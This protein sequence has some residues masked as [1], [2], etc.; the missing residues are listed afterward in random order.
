M[1]LHGTKL[2]SYCCVMPLIDRPGLDD[3]GQRM[4][5][6]M[7]EPEGGFRDIL[8]TLETPESIRKKDGTVVH[9]DPNQIAL[10]RKIV[11]PVEK[12]GRGA[13][14]SLRIQE[15]E[16]AAAATWPPAEQIQMGDWL[17]RATG[18]FTGRANS[19]LPLGKPPFGNPGKPLMDALTDVI[20]FYQE[21]DLTPLIHVSLPTYEE[22]D[23]ELTQWGWEKRIF[24]SVMVSDIDTSMN[25]TNSDGIWEVADRPSDE[26][27]SVQDDY[28]VQE[29]MERA[30]SFYIGLRIK[31]ELVAVGRGANYEKWTTLSRLFVRK[32]YR[33]RGLG[34]ELVQ[35]IL[36]E[37]QVRGAT[38]ALLQVSMENEVA[39]R[40]YESLGFVQHH[41]YHYR[42]YMPQPVV[43]ESC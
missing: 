20:A 3:L 30:P 9:F 35:H 7:H 4:T 21:R 5:I 36:Q 16:L 27:I 24:A 23:R 14:L 38:K 25:R 42:A 37:A 39:I 18:K 15:I 29:I 26:W 8:G 19:V 17:L 1:A 2:A 22:L 6:R 28:G 13:P 12:A 34:R 32:D 40:L 31:G 11:P 43:E 10:W 41:T 33:G